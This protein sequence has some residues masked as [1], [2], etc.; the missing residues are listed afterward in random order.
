M[1]Q[2]ELTAQSD[3][4]ASEEIEK[5]RAELREQ[6]HLADIGELAGQVTH[7]FNNFLNSLL[8]KIALLETEL[9]EPAAA[10]FADIKQQ[11][12]IMADVIKQVHHFQRR[13]PSI[14]SL[15]LNPVIKQTAAS[16]GSESDTV[17]IQ[18]SLSPQPALVSGSLVDFQRLISFLLRNRIAAAGPANRTLL[19]RTEVTER[20]LFSVEDAGSNLPAAALASLFDGDGTDEGGSRL[21]LAACKALV[22][23]NQGRIHAKP[24]PAG[25]VTIGMEFPLA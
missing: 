23:R 14:E 18:L 9:P 12:K 19:L 11:A 5:L 10:K 16:I 8:L 20:V 2:E 17:T 4:R 13:Q 24:A 7:K 3:P 6:I 25:G 1:S 21:E 15:D 22:R